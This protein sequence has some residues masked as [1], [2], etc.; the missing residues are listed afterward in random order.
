MVALNDNGRGIPPHIIHRVFEPFFTT[1]NSSKGTGL[2]LSMVYGFTRQSGGFI[3]IDSGE[4]KGTSVKL[5]FP[6]SEEQLPAAT[7]PAQTADNSETVPL[8]T[9]SLLVV[10]DRPDVLRYLTQTLRELGYRVTQAGDAQQALKKMA[11]RKNLDMLL[12]DVVMPGEM[13]GEMLAQEALKRMPNLK[14][15]YMSG[16]TRDALQ[17]QG[18]LKEGV[19]LLSKPFTRADLAK[20]VRQVLDA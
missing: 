2:G 14:V 1:K 16:Y 18:A 19:T 4:S 20:Q 15:L 3:T 13:N 17:E 9:E 6:R 11:K 8:G 12:T 7:Q 10:E 5:F